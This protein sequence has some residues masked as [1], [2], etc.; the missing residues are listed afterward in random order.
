[1]ATVF[2]SSLSFA[3]LAA[4][5]FTHQTRSPPA[6]DNNSRKVLAS[7][8]GFVLD[9]PEAEVMEHFG[10]ELKDETDPNE[11]E[12]I[13]NGYL[14]LEENSKDRTSTSP[15]SANTPGSLSSYGSLPSS[16]PL[17]S[18]G[19][20]KGLPFQL[21]PTSSPFGSVTPSTFYPDFLDG[22]GTYLPMKLDSFQIHENDRRVENLFLVALDLVRAYKRPPFDI[23]T[24]SNEMKRIDPNYDVRATSWGRFLE[25]CKHMSAKGY[26]YLTRIG[27]IPMVKAYGNGTKDRAKPNHLPTMPPS[28]HL[29]VGSVGPGV[30]KEQ[31]YALFAPCGEIESVSMHT[32]M[33]YAFIDFL[34]VTEAAV[35]KEHLQG[36]LVGDKKITINFAKGEASRSLC[37]SGL[38]DISEEELYSEF[39]VYGPIERVSFVPETGCAYIDF[40]RKE[41]SIS[42]FYSM[43]DRIVG[44]RRVQLDF[45]KCRD[46]FDAKQDLRSGRSP[47]CIPESGLA[48]SSLPAHW[49]A[50]LQKRQALQQRLQKAVDGIGNEV[51]ELSRYLL[52]ERESI[53]L[54]DLCKIL[55]Q[56][57]FNVHGPGGLK[58]LLLKFPDVF[59]FTKELDNPLVYLRERERILFDLPAVGASHYVSSHLPPFWGG[60]W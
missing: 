33:G 12:H 5:G 4:Y 49:T 17:S 8:F 16:P 55:V 21:S 18:L 54:N 32:N 40:L 27:G 59:A 28:R 20:S 36:A 2:P 43:Q 19:S 53:R 58:S 34:H 47:R 60:S 31:L 24:I 56:G 29:W 57:G 9:I 14:S 37:I 25:L 13:F 44:Q 52:N 23:N 3:G 15:G 39:S 51:V 26:L 7:T 42:A 48:I 50:S 30:T 35:A 6:P 41:D 1:M 10:S 45:S 46:M 11:L 38:T 22:T